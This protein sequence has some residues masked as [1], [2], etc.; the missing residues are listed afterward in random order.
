MKHVIAV[1]LVLAT[2]AVGWWGAAGW[3]K[4]NG[5]LKKL[6]DACQAAQRENESLRQQKAA[7]ESELAVLQEQN[8]DAN[9]TLQSWR[10]WS[11]QLQTALGGKE[12]A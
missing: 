3:Q 8:R 9:E 11:E 5:E 2:L 6:Q 10:D 7:L 1:L 4:E 12:T